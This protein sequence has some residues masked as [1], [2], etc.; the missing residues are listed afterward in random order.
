MSLAESAALRRYYDALSRRLLWRRLIGAG[1]GAEKLTM[2]R[3]LVD[4][5]NPS[6]APC[7]LV[8]ERILDQAL[9]WRRLGDAFDGL[10]IGCGYGGVSLRLAAARGGRW[11]GLTLSPVQAA[12]A[13]RTAR[14]R[15]L[16]NRAR[17]LVRSYDAP[18]AP[19][20]RFDA[21][22]AIESLIHSPDKA[23][24]LANIAAALKPGA[25][26][27]IIDDVAQFGDAA[28]EAALQ[29]ARAQFQAGWMAPTTPDEAAWAAALA[30]AGLVVEQVQDLTALSRPRPEPELARAATAIR[31]RRAPFWR[32]RDQEVVKQGEIGGLALERLYNAGA[33]RY[34]LMVARKS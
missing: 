20:E 3:R 29:G 10:D 6:A 25:T 11:L 1:E 15:G 17:Y 33:M 5:A 8:L 14:R 2:H 4:P 27:A 23:A 9:P 34:L 16:A 24:T 7:P 32:R 31:A 28:Q 22:F 12:H 13:T 18:F 30:R 21:A 19:Q 26:L